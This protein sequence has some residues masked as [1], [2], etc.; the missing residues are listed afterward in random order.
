MDALT[1][2]QQSLRERHHRLDEK[3]AEEMKS[4]APDTIQVAIWK[5][6]KLRLKEQLE[7]S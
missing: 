5:K 4:H 7:L 1:A 2:H 3:I 6:E